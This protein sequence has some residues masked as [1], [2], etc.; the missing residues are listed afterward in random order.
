MFIWLDITQPFYS[1]ANKYESIL[2]EQ[3][4]DGRLTEERVVV[5]FKVF[6]QILPK[7]GVYRAVIKLLRDHLFGRLKIVEHKTI[8]KMS[9]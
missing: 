7:L 5:L 1:I 2:A 9:F 8:V 4:G 6:D 3:S